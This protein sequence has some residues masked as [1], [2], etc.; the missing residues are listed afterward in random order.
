MEISASKVYWGVLLGSIPVGK[1]RE[2]GLWLG[3]KAGSSGVGM[4]YQRYCGKEA[5]PS[6]PIIDQSLDA[7][8][9]RKL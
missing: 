8:C 7:D 6:Y 1:E 5:R 2:A 3:G 9:P 4:H